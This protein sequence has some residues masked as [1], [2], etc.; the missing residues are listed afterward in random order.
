MVLIKK[1]GK[2]KINSLPYLTYFQQAFYLFFNGIQIIKPYYYLDYAKK[3]AQQ[4]LIKNYDWEYYGGHHHENVFTKFAITYWMYKKFDIDKRKITLSAQVL[5]GE[6][7]RQEALRIIEKHPYEQQEMELH[8][9]YVIK[10]LG[11]S[12]KE[13]EQIW[14]LNNKSIDD[15]PSYLNLI[16]RLAIVIKPLIKLVYKNT[17]T[18]VFQIEKRKSNI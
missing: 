10:K 15:Y 17:P 1:F 11:L 4:F 6:I 2:G 13:F 16:N 8:K 12:H 14:K 7:T 5:S 9:D 18:F 3:K